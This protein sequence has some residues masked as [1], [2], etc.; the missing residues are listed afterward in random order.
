MWSQRVYNFMTKIAKDSVKRSAATINNRAS[1][2]KTPGAPGAAGASGAAGAFDA[3][4]DAPNT[5]G[6][7]DAPGKLSFLQLISQHAQPQSRRQSLVNAYREAFAQEMHDLYYE[8]WCQLRDDFWVANPDPDENRRKKIG[9][10]PLV[11][12]DNTFENL[13]SK[14]ILASI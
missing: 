14:F 3:A 2:V 5:A 11:S 6:A 1:G 12:T 10:I 8:E 7:P 9:V 13:I 4:A